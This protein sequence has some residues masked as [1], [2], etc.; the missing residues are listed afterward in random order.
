MSM[1]GCVAGGVGW[2]G[3]LECMNEIITLLNLFIF[4]KKKKK[5]KRKKVF[6]TFIHD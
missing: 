1:C 2:G 5:K 6:I 3:N 4:L